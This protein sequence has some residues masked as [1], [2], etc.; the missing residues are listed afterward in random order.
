MDGGG[1]LSAGNNGEPVGKEVD[2]YEC[3]LVNALYIY[4][5]YEGGV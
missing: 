4:M 2:V 3:L 5:L 1:V